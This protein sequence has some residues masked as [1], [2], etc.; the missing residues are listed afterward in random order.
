[1]ALSI[2]SCADDNVKV[3]VGVGLPVLE[4]GNVGE[5]ILGSVLLSSFS[6]G[7][8]FQDNI[9]ENIFSPGIYGDFHFG[10]YFSQYQTGIRLYNQ[11][12]F[13]NLDLYPFIGL[14]SMY[15][16]FAQNLLGMYGILV[17]YK[18]IGLEY[19]YQPIIL[20]YS[21]L[22]NKNMYRIIFVIRI[23]K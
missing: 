7:M 22:I 14:N 9:V 6:F 15:G 10:D 21:D 1:M 8:G 18:R 2:L 4:D 3:N 12:R 5:K 17:G 19:S 13:D 16:S 23:V 20:N 11:F